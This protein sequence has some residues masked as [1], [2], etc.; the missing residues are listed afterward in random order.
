MENN[1][2][3][4]IDP[5]KIRNKW[6]E[7]DDRPLSMY[8]ENAQMT[9]RVYWGYKREYSFGLMN[10][11]T[12]CNTKCFYCS[13]YW[14]PPDVIIAYPQWLTMDEIKHFLTFVPN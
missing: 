4:L 1:T 2:Q 10:V 5:A 7:F 13:Q 11:G 6:V 14:N 9:E 12:P 3:T 8:Q